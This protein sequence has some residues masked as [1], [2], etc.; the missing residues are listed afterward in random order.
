MRIVGSVL[1]G[2]LLSGG[3]GL[4]LTGCGTNCQS[5]CGRAFRTSECNVI[6]PGQTQED[7]YSNCVLECQRALRRPGDLDGYEPDQ[8]AGESVILDNE[9][10]AAVWMDCVEETS[11]ENLSDRYCA[12]G[13]I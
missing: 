2:L 4:G 8:P 7:L 1:V 11:C 3:L 5:A 13:G 6:R 12:G 10:Q 9:R